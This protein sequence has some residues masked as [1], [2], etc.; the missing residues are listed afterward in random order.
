MVRSGKFADQKI[1]IYAG[2]DKS[3]MFIDGEFVRRPK[4]DLKRMVKTGELKVIFGTDAA[5]EGLNLQTL[6]TLINIDLP[7]NPTRLEQRKGRIQ[8]IGQKFDVIQIYNMRYAGSVEDKVHKVLAERLKY[9]NEIFGQVPDTLEAVWT[10]VAKDQI[11]QAKKTINEVPPK[12]SFETKYENPKM[13]N[14]Y[15]WE[16]CNKVLDEF[17]KIEHFMQKW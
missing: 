8:R 16:E 9:F 4:E 10:M 1:A 13:A 12:S 3:G 17:I 11:E 6:G 5:S 15:N 14:A 2:G 7:W